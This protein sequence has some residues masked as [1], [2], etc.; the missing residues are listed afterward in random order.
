M[1]SSFLIQVLEEQ[2]LFPPKEY[3]SSITTSLMYIRVS[4]SRF[5]PRSKKNTVNF[6]FWVYNFGGREGAGAPGLSRSVWNLPSSL[7]HLESFSCMCDIQLQHLGSSSQPGIE[8]ESP[9]LGA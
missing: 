6:V 2:I 9:E 4:V 8:P 7:W 3:I 5:W 1:G